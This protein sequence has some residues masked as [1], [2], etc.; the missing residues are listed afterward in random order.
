MR[1]RIW[2]LDAFRG[3]CIL[4]MVLVHLVYDLVELYRILPW[5]YPGWFS[6]VKDWGGV[7]FVVLSGV[8]ATLGSRSVKR[9]LIVFAAG[10]LCTAVTLAMGFFGFN[11]PIYFGVLHCLGA[12]MIAWWVFKRLPTAVLGVLGAVLVAAGLWLREQVFPTGMWLMPLG[13]TPPNFFS[14]DYFPLLPNLG[15][16]LMGAVLG[17]L[18]YGKKESLLPRVPADKGILAFFQFCGRQ[19]LLIYLLHQP[20]LSGICVLLGMIK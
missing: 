17:R 11:I 12:C 16:F 2:E 5:Q 3:V 20:V 7:L 4:G 18:A 1:K 13:L 8:C 9:G 10:M 19:S 14:T 6:F 15:Y